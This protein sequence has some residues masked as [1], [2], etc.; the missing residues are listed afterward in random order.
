MSDQTEYLA[1]RETRPVP[2]SLMMGSGSPVVNYYQGRLIA[3]H[4]VAVDRAGPA[5]VAVCGATVHGRI[6]GLFQTN[7]AGR[8]GECAELASRA[9]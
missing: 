1:W 4:A 5:D 8:C 6:N 3:T 7:V 2:S 9:V